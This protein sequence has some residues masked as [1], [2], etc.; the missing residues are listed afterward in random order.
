MNFVTGEKLQELTE[1]SVALN[2]ESNFSSILVKTQLKNT[3]T[4]CFVFDPNTHSNVIPEEIKNAKSIFVY[5]HILPFFFENIL[6]KI[7]SQFTLISHNSDNGV[8]NTMLPY[9]D[10]PKIKKWFCQNKYVF[11]PKIFSLPIGIAN[12]QWSHGNLQILEKVINTN[13]PKNN[14]VYKNF[15]I[16]T[17]PTHRSQADQDTTKN[18]FPMHPSS[19]FE[20]Y[21]KQIKQSYFCFAP[22]GNGADCHR[23]W[24][25]LYLRCVPI[26]P[27]RDYCFDDFKHLPI[28]FVD[29]FKCITKEFLEEKIN[30]FYTE[31]TYNLDMLTIE[32]WK[33]QINE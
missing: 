5:T 29:N 15:D 13:L 24:E 7:E 6:P 33:Q 16:D 1:V 4:K 17:N 3:K 10:S 23:I 2:I 25:C 27:K 9:A 19:S 22:L 12:S 30:S 14:L 21:I 32:Y 8:E 18:G 26:V 28:L 20:E 11:H 31:F